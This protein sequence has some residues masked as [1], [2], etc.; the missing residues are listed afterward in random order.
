MI[1]L[2]YK[3]MGEERFQAG[4]DPAFPVVHYDIGPLQDKNKQQKITG[5]C[6]TD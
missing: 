5:I 3:Y 6:V 2:R 4:V 1:T